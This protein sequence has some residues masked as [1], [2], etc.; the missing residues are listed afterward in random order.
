MCGAMPGS[1]F[2]VGC[3]YIFAWGSGEDGQLGLEEAQVGEDDWNISI[4]TARSVPAL[5]GPHCTL[6]NEGSGAVGRFINQLRLCR[7]RL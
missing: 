2:S 4:P 5:W 1:Q 6:Q 3:S 7:R